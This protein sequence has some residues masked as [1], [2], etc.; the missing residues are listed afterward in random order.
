MTGDG[1]CYHL[2]NNLRESGRVVKWKT[3]SVSLPKMGEGEGGGEW[4]D[5]RAKSSPARRSACAPHKALAGGTSRRQGLRIGESG[6]LFRAKKR[7]TPLATSTYE[8]TVAR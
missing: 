6:L 8:S 4:K 2:E 1:L 3:P 5:L 7:R